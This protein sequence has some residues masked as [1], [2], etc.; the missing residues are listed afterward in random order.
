L[1]IIVMGVAGAGKSTLGEAL[2][3]ALGWPFVEGDDFH[4]AANREKMARGEALDEDDRDP[5]LARL[6]RRMAAL[7]G[8]RADAVVACSALRA[9]YR[10]RLADGLRDVRFVF[11]DGGRETIAQ[12]LRERRNH[13]MPPA[14]LES[15]LAALEPPDGAIR[16][17]VGLDTEGQVASVLG[18]IRGE[19]SK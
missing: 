2:A 17:P 11:L 13:F 10:E 6:H 5:W 7:D 16:V 9:R 15:Q 4:P 3:A 18:R 14:L 19:T 8:A 12:R 1:I